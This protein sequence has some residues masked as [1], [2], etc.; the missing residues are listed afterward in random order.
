MPNWCANSCRMTAPQDNPMM[1]KILAALTGDGQWFEAVKPVPVP[2][3]DAIANI[4]VEPTDEQKKL[5]EEFGH[6]S[7]FD[8]CVDEWGTKWEAK[9]DSF[10]Q[11]GDSVTVYF[12]TAWSPPEGI[13]KT[14]E[15]AGIKVE[16]TYA[17]QG[18]GYM[19]YRKDGEDYCCDMPEY[20]GEDSPEYHQAIDKVW[21][22]AGMGHFPT[23]LGG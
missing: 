21:D 18:I 23:N 11:D 22:D 15:A 10:E 13:Y 14:M 1:G 20:D 19:G 16:A 8:Y 4:N 12:D 6:R 17:E 7:W 2:L 9:I 3:K 5:I